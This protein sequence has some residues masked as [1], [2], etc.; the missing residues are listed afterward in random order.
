MRIEEQRVVLEA[1]LR[2]ARYRIGELSAELQRWSRRV[3]E[4]EQELE[5]LGQMELPGMP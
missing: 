3:Y 5:R 1:T 2:E 4:I